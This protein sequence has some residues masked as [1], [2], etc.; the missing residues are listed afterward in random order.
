MRFIMPKTYGCV[1]NYVLLYM[2]DQPSWT[3][4]RKKAAKCSSSMETSCQ[5]E[6]RGIS[7]E[8]F[9]LG[10]FLAPGAIEP[11]WLSLDLHC[12]SSRRSVHARLLNWVLIQI[13]LFFAFARPSK[14]SHINKGVRN[15]YLEG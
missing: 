14:H 6:I 11:I 13:T 2:V 9:A 12:G 4:Y 5:A 3:K 15:R 10:F 7:F 8:I 1:Y